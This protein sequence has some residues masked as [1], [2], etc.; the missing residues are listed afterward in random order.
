MAYLSSNITND[1]IKTFFPE[2]MPENA[3]FAFVNRK[4]YLKEIFFA[5]NS[6]NIKLLFLSG[7]QGTGKTELIHLINHSLQENIL[8][9][10]YECSE[11]TNLD[12]IILGLYSYLHKF[13]EKNTENIRADKHL[14]VKS[15]DEKLINLL[16]N[17]KLPIVIIFDGF[18]HLTEDRLNLSDSE[19]L[20][21]IN[22]LLSLS[23]VKLVISG[24]K[25]PSSGFNIGDNNILKIKLGGI[26]EDD[27]IKILN[28]R[29]IQASEQTIS[30]IHRVTRG[31]P[32]NI[33]WIVCISNI[34]HV[35][36]FEIIQEYASKKESFEDFISKKA[37]QALTDEY[38]NITWILATIR[39]SVTK[40]L[41][42]QL[43]PSFFPDE[44]LKY[45][46][47][48]MVITCNNNFYYIKS[49][50]KD[51]IYNNIPLHEK[52]RIH[53]L[54]HEVYAEQI[55]KKI[56]DRIIKIS[57]KLLHSEQY[58]HYM[59]YT[60]PGLEIQTVSNKRYYSDPTDYKSSLTIQTE[61]HIENEYSTIKD[62]AEKTEEKNRI[63]KDS[64]QHDKNLS[65]Q[66]NMEI[67]YKTVDD[68]LSIDLTE[69]EKALLEDVTIEQQTEKSDNKTPI[70]N[71][72]PEKEPVINN[73]ESSILPED[74]IEELLNN[75]RI[76]QNDKKYDLA[77][78]NFNKT[79]SLLEKSKTN[80]F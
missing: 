10:Y 17:L 7:F 43:N 39:H 8:S 24:R 48:N 2:K 68:N 34:L 35:S 60:K 51:I 6:N 76:F 41:L 44:S 14:A 29:N 26:Q 9:F 1:D 65:Q 33:H 79:V 74:I 13:I 63:L 54:L 19:L 20:K 4:E 72:G 25:V 45:L 66:H 64:N 32:E 56:N 15:I 77:L 38:K 53:K 58:H 73:I 49:N 21:F 16:K 31:Y 12:D 40:N 61:S 27:T 46:V 50:L 75:A 52:V 69:E 22:F 28:H 42:N 30:Q 70:E 57:R 55:P 59:R 67:L 47:N 23:G 80:L 36:P 18:E 3:Y 37:Y 11:I 78:K 62:D 71:S 5:L